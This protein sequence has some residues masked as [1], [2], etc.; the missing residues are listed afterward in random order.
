MPC[1]TA[2]Y[3]PREDAS[4]VNRMRTGQGLSC[5]T[6]NI[7]AKIR[8]ADS[9]LRGR[10]ELRGRV[11]ESHPEVCFQMLN[12]GASL[13]WNKKAG[14]GLRERMCILR[15]HCPSADRVYETALAR[16][17]RSELARD[18]ILDALVLAVTAAWPGRLR[19]LPATPERDSAGLPMEIVYPG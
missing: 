4:R 13:R 3:A 16:Y 17:R 15:R 10:P 9:L 8:A 19:T 12:G 2:V 7:I 11:R 14:D 5:Q 1:R 18:D 6:L